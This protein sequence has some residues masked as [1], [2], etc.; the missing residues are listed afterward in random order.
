MIIISGV[1]WFCQMILSDPKICTT[2]L[3]KDGESNRSSHGIHCRNLILNRCNH[4]A[5]VNIGFFGH[6]CVRKLRLQGN[7]HSTQ[8][9]A[10][11]SMGCCGSTARNW[12][13][14]WR[15]SPRWSVL[16]FKSPD[17]TQM[18]TVLCIATT[19]NRSC[20]GA[21]GSCKLDT[22]VSSIQ[23][24]CRIGKKIKQ[25]EKSLQFLLIR[26]PYLLLKIP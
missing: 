5:E 7:A 19:P 16:F 17:I 21:L 3:Q 25:Q 24:D 12:G 11:I 26:N 9:V 15:W 6:L 20:P 18:F 10:L 1:N 4:I 23:H 2:K 8:A 14:W 13:R 22:E